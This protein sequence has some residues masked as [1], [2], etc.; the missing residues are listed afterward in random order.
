MLTGGPGG[1]AVSNMVFDNYEE[2]FYISSGI[3]QSEKVSR[4]ITED[5]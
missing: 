3:A 2:H 5:D 4:E 1:P